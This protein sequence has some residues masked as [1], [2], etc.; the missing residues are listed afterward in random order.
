VKKITYS[1][2]LFSAFSCSGFFSPR[3][4]DVTFILGDGV[5]MEVG[6]ARFIGIDIDEDMGMDEVAGMSTFWWCYEIEITGSV[7]WPVDILQS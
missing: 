6:V 7:P 4:G 5:A 3:I 2:I 1:I